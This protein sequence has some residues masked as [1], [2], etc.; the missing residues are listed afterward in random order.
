MDANLPREKDIPLLT[1][2]LKIVSRLFDHII[3]TKVFP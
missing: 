3:E 2:M 1:A